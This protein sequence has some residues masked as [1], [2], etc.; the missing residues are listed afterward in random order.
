MSGDDHDLLV[1]DAS[2][3]DGGA[4]EALLERHWPGLLAY[5]RLHADPEIRRH[6]SCADI[7]Q[8]VCREA[9]E[10]MAGFEYHG[11]APFRKWLFMRALSKLVNRKRYWLRE[12]RDAGREQ[13]V[14]QLEAQTRLE[15]LY[16]RVC[17][18]SQ[19]AIAKET[20]ARLEA[21]FTRL[22]DDYRQ[23]ITL[24]RVIGMSH[25]EIALEMGRELGAVRVLLHRALARLGRLMHEQHGSE[26]DDAPHG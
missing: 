19:G 15:G 18:P 23:V 22:P 16:A 4:I 14:S 17:S 6:E 5:I 20:A 7:A 25:A 8:S 21:T 1:R 12:R 10:D 26:F 2:R 13:R 3:G 9:L 11:E 24:S